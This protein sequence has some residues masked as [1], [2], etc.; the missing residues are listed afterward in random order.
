MLRLIRICV[1]TACLA[2][3]TTGAMA[4]PTVPEAGAPEADIN[5]DTAPADALPPKPMTDEEIAAARTAFEISLHHQIGRI[6]MMGDG[7]TLNVPGSF[8]FLNSID[9]QKVL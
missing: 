2:F 4:Q 3:S 6:P 8:Y 5:A 1:A 9:T 7:V